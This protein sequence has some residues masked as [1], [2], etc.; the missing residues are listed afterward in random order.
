MNL[1][2]SLAERGDLSA[3]VKLLERALEI[4]PDYAEAHNNLGLVL[5]RSGRQ[6][7]AARA[8]PAGGE[9]RSALRGRAQ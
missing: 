5:V 7:A 2:A 1:A 3:A 9:N 8:F 6:E 4:Q